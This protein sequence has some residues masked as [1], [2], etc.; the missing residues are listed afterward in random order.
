MQLEQ[1]INLIGENFQTLQRMGVESLAVFG[2]TAR[3]EAQPGSDV[4]ILVT[5]SGS[6]TY[7]QYIESK[8]FLEDLL[9]CKVNLVPREELKPVIRASVEEEA[10]SVA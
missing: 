7:D 3:G 9:G 10:V 6:P 1:V 8:F 5:F 4:D 2:S